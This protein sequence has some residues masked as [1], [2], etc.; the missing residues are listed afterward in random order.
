MFSEVVNI[1]GNR[2]SSFVPPGNVQR[3]CADSH[4]CIDFP[5]WLTRNEQK[6]SGTLSWRATIY[7]S[8]Q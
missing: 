3:C 8:V 1:E 4:R 6:R 2:S 7:S 5:P